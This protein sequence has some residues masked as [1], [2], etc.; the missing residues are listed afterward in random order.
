MSRSSDVATLS[1]S[2]DICYP[3]KM[4]NLWN[5][6]WSRASIDARQ[7]RHSRAFLKLLQA[8]LHD[9]ACLSQLPLVSSILAWTNADIWFWYWISAYHHLRTDE[10]S[11]GISGRHILRNTV[12]RVEL[13]LVP[14]GRLWPSAMTVPTVDVLTTTVAAIT[15]TIVFLLLL[16]LFSSLLRQLISVY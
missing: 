7:S 16:L 9:I 3:L 1:Q 5:F 15:A 6:D 10:K 11:P 14:L 13:G 4:T 8:K 12:S 2:S